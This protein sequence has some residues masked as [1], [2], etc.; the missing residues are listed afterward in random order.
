MAIGPGTI[1]VKRAAEG[2]RNDSSSCELL[3]YHLAHYS[4]LALPDAHHPFTTTNDVSQR[5]RTALAL[6]RAAKSN[7]DEDWGFYLRHKPIAPDVF[8]RWEETG[9]QYRSSKSNKDWSAWL[10]DKVFVPES[11]PII[12]VGSPEGYLSYKCPFEDDEYVTPFRKLL[13]E[14]GYSAQ[15]RLEGHIYGEG[16]INHGTV[17]TPLK[18]DRHAL[19]HDLGLVFL[20]RTKAGRTVV[21][22]AGAT[23]PFGTFAAARLASDYGRNEVNAMAMDFFESNS[24]NHCA[25]AFFAKRVPRP[26]ELRP[27]SLQ[28][29]I[30]I[31][32]IEQMRPASTRS[33]LEYRRLEV[34]LQKLDSTP[35]IPNSQTTPL[36]QFLSAKGPV[37]IITKWYENDLRDD[38]YAMK[39]LEYSLDDT[40]NY[41]VAAEIAE[42]FEEHLGGDKA[43]GTEI[44]QQLKRIVFNKSGPV[45]EAINTLDVDTVSLFTLWEQ[46]LQKR[47]DQRSPEAF[48]KWLDQCYRLPSDGATIVLGSP[49]SFLGFEHS[50]DSSPKTRFAGL[51]HSAQYPNRYQ[52]RLTRN[53]PDQFIV[54]YDHKTRRVLEHSWIKKLSKERLREDAGFIGLSKGANGRDILTIAGVSWLGTLA[55]V[56]LLFAQQ[57]P[58]IDALIQAYARGER[59]RIDIYFTCYRT[60]HEIGF[61]RE[62]SRWQYFDEPKDLEIDTHDSELEPEFQRN[63][64]AEKLFADL[65]KALDDRNQEQACRKVSLDQKDEVFQ[66][67]DSGGEHIDQ[68]EVFFEVSLSKTNEKRRLT[69]NCKRPICMGE[70]DPLLCG[71]VVHSIFRKLEHCVEQDSK[72]LLKGKYCGKYSVLGAPGVGKESF[73][74]FVFIKRRKLKNDAHFC[75]VN[76][77]SISPDLVMS[78]LFGHDKGGFTGAEERRI[79]RFQESNEG[80]VFLDEF[81]VLNV[82]KNHALPSDN[83]NATVLQTSLLRAMESCTYSPV[84]SNKEIGIRCLLV[85]ATNIAH[86]KSEL[87]NLVKLG[88][89]RPD[90]RDRFAG[91]I[92]VMPRLA[93]R[94]M[95]ILPGF[96]QKIRALYSVIDEDPPEVEMSVEAIKL[97]LMHDF[98]GNFRNLKEFAEAIVSN[99]DQ[100]HSLATNKEALRIDAYH[101]LRAMGANDFQYPANHPGNE[102]LKIEILVN[103]KLLRSFKGSEESRV[104]RPADVTQSTISSTMSSRTPRRSVS[105]PISETNTDD[106]SNP[107]SGKKKIPLFKLPKIKCAESFT[108]YDSRKTGYGQAGNGNERAV[109]Q[110]KKA[111]KKMQ[112]MNWQGE[113]P[114][115]LVTELKSIYDNLIIGS[116]K[117]TQ[118]EKTCNSVL[119]YFNAKG[120]DEAGHETKFHFYS[121]SETQ[122]K[123]IIEKASELNLCFDF[124]AIALTVAFGIEIRSPEYKMLC[125][126]YRMGKDS[127]FEQFDGSVSTYSKK[128]ILDH[129]NSI[130]AYSGDKAKE[131]NLM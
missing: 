127:C 100:N 17:S 1:I 59:S 15:Y 82:I 55:G 38:A 74:Y 91:R 112:A 12:I 105:G 14:T 25:I 101:L 65:F 69:I 124:L 118:F 42:Y 110:V 35:V 7:D 20:G 87:D 95:E 71:P 30:N 10:A 52:L 60:I 62:N 116:K 66:V 85:V 130:N 84:G 99:L 121:S 46:S 3:Q 125:H 16:A 114:S 61:G 67:S 73:A 22:L 33:D 79:S 83:R 39:I 21:V 23:S 129:I 126:L 29:P 8:D 77:A 64:R 104:N 36:A 117:Q 111:V 97:L 90:V 94:P 86:Y 31:D 41:P 43:N 44:Q 56:R 96:I 18:R 102:M 70:K 75:T 47:N 50:H 131:S 54:I 45:V 92:F 27:F 103:G 4:Y 49:E 108:K 24:P 106:A 48:A 123:L 6:L 40:I 98:P 51:L 57:R 88:Y 122:V 63:R 80:V 78:E 13:S 19:Q 58:S 113:M 5:H 26:G 81:S 93:D 34:E 109:E 89:F 9:K 115:A 120:Y 37:N 32:F 76:S 11:G 28:D 119:W 2:T 107:K 68:R 72:R 53:G 128:E